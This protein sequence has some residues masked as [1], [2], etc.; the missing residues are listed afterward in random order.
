M[1]SR[2]DNIDHTML[3]VKTV[4][5]SA[6]AKPL[7]M[8]H[9]AS[10][11]AM[12]MMDAANGHARSKRFNETSVSTTKHYLVNDHHYGT[13]SLASLFNE[14]QEL[15][16]TRMTNKKDSVSANGSTSPLESLQECQLALHNIAKTITYH[17]SLDV[18]GEDLP[19]TLP[20]REVLEAKVESYFSQANSILPVFRKSAFCEN[21]QRIYTAATDQADIAWIICFNNIIL[22]TLSA[23][24]IQHPDES[25][26][27]HVTQRNSPEK[28]LLQPLLVNYRRGLKRTDRLLEPKLVNV[29]A[30]LLMVSNLM[31]SLD[32]HP[33]LRG[34]F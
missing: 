22:Q 26:E 18:P 11:V 17:D 10:S 31:P 29:Q 15:I 14:I 33:F 8:N 5:D 24:T 21:I 25:D 34:A 2:L 16:D 9:D 32:L 30:L 7:S 3:Q 19:P 13:S 1:K 12:Y 6:T 4:V 23:D 27:S 28:E 20:P